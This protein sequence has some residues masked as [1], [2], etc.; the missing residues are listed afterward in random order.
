M[1]KTLYR[2][3]IQNTTSLISTPKSKYF[4]LIHFL[5]RSVMTLIFYSTREFVAAMNNVFAAAATTMPL[6]L[7]LC[8]AVVVI[9]ISSAGIQ[10]LDRIL[11]KTYLFLVKYLIT[12]IPC[13][14]DIYY[15]YPIYIIKF[16]YCFYSFTFFQKH[17]VKWISTYSRIVWNIPLCFSYEFGKNSFYKLYFE[18]IILLKHSII[19]KCLFIKYNIKFRFHSSN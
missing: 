10:A 2:S 4:L 12:I 17:C 18:F 16:L 9:Y 1:N 14:S 15:I 13:N 5:S 6:G 19:C 7:W 3:T 8:L 11:E